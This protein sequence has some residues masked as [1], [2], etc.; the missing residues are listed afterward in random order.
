MAI[1]LFGFTIG[2]KDEK[3]QQKRDSSSFT[4]KTTEDGAL[5]VSAAGA[6]FIN[7]MVDIDG[8]VRTE[9]ELVT[10]YREMALQPEIDQAVDEIVNEVITSTPDDKLIELKL[11]RLEESYGKKVSTLIQNEFDNVLRLLDFN[12]SAYDIFRRWYIDGRL[13]YHV[14]I[15]EAS[16]S[17]GIK[18]V[19]YV[20]PRKIRKIR[21][22]T[23]K[24]VANGVTT[25]VARNEYFVYSER[26]FSKTLQDSANTMAGLTHHNVQGV[27][28]A[29]DAIIHVV[30]GK[31]DSMN[32]MVLSY[33]H[34]AI[35][36]LNQL[37]G[38]EDARIIYSLV[39]A[40][41]RRIFYIDVG[42]LPKMKAEQYVKDMMVRH[43]NKLIYDQNTGEIGDS[44]RMM[45]M[46]EDYWFP[47]REG[48][49]GTEVTTLQGG[50]NLGQMEEV[51]YFKRQLLTS[52]Q[53]PI[54]RLQADSNT[55]NFG[56]AAEITREEVKFQ[57][58]IS[59]LRLRFSF[60]FKEL[61]SRQLVLKKIVAAE[62][63]S[64]L[65]DLIKFDFVTDNSYAE[66]K[67]LEVTKERM[68]VAMD[69]DQL[70]EKGYVEKIWIARHIL[71]LPDDQLEQVEQR[72]KKAE[73]EAEFAAAGPD[74]PFGAPQ[75][76]QQAAP[77]ERQQG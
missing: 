45:H 58:F 75:Q 73:A 8:T 34:Q 67:E 65:I 62:E 32:K 20:D 14:I 38:I 74:T 36:P 13:Y 68:A 42:N 46:L 1:E 30:S 27:K 44:R 60:L 72:I 23:P 29:K 56:R 11:E 59:R 4:P 63:V 16:P 33:L 21:E 22:V 61:L 18:E 55:F 50:A 49:K 6:N 41:E 57:K 25:L 70:A 19:R 39:R 28:I 31:M 76:D 15:D 24:T 7:N 37:R 10:R 48:G 52:L 43:K 9:A 12:N 26:G 51:D 54:G 5:L 17:E 71:R 35:K 47:R 69:M 2:R 77:A 3:D 66:L 40:P 64:D 53:V